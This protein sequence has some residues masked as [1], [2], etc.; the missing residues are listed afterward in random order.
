MARHAAGAGAKG[1]LLEQGDLA[2]GTGWHI[3]GPALGLKGPATNDVFVDK[4]EL[5]Y[6]TDR[7]KGFNIIE[8]TEGAAPVA[9]RHQHEH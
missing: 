6:I 1:R 8:R 4:R 7:D 9:K 3:P 5:I 2:R